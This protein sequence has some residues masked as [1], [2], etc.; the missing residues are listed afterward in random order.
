MKQILL[1][2]DRTRRQQL[3]SAQTGI[4]LENFNDI[5][6]NRIEDRYDE[7]LNEILQDNFDLSPYDIIVSHKSAFGDNNGSVL[8]KLEDHCREYGKSLVLFSGGIVGNYYNNEEYEELGLNS[9]TFYSQNL[10]LFLEAVKKQNGNLLMLC[11]GKEW[12]LNIML[13]VLEHLNRYIDT[14]ID[15]LLDKID[16]DSLEQIGI[17]CDKINI[18]DSMEKMIGFRECL[19]KIIKGFADE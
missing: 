10:T 11:Y 9:K 16:L 6:D 2:E 12:K 13:N 17:E 7:F 15:D 4:K 18:N 3:F 14:E 8:K 19:L 1:I 5:L